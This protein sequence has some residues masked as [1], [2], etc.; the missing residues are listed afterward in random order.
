M[1]VT[2]QRMG[3]G[4]LSEFSTSGG[5]NLSGLRYAG[6]TCDH[7]EESGSMIE[8]QSP[9]LETG[10]LPSET[11]ALR[12]LVVDDEPRIVSL[13][14]LILRYEGFSVAVAEDGPSALR[15]VVRFRPHLI[16]LD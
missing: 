9:S 3:K 2:P 12:V 5:R 7:H 11:E 15:E 10:S 6:G 16:I 13:L 1:T 14:K 8:P 4:G